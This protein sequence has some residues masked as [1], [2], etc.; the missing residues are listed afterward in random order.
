VIDKR[1][2]MRWYWFRSLHLLDA[3]DRDAVEELLIE[4]FAVATC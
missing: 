2:A 4:Q 1:A 3:E